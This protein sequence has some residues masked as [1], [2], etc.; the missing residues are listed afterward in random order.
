MLKNIVKASLLANL[1]NKSKVFKQAPFLQPRMCSSAGLRQLFSDKTSAARRLKLSPCA[2][3]YNFQKI[4]EDRLEIEVSKKG[5][6]VNLQNR[7]R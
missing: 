5:N 1:N 7:V 2:L 6:F 3:L 4:T